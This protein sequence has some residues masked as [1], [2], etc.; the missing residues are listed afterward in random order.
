M[1]LVTPVLFLLCR[2]ETSAVLWFH[3]ALH[4]L[5]KLES[6][7]LLCSDFHIRQIFLWPRGSWAVSTTTSTRSRSFTPK[8]FQSCFGARPSFRT[9]CFCFFICL[10]R[11]RID[12]LEKNSYGM[13]PLL[14]WAKNK[15]C[16]VGWGYIRGW[17]WGYS[18]QQNNKIAQSTIL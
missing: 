11:Q 15:N 4:Q 9:V 17:G 5:F 18:D 7:N 12:S 6:N 1:P 10:G 8:Q 3:E 14:R 2:V 16:C 13:T